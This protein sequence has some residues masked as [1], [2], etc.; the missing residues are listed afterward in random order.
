MNMSSLDT[1]FAGFVDNYLKLCELL[2]SFDLP[3]YTLFDEFK[4]M[5]EKSR[6]ILCVGTGR[7]GDVADILSKFLRNIGFHSYGPEELPYMFSKDDLVIAISGSGSTPYTLEIARFAKDIGIPIVGFTSNMDSPLARFLDLVFHIPG[8]PRRKPLRYEVVS[9]SGVYSTPLLMLGGTL[10]EL[11]SLLLI[12]SFI[13]YM[14]LGLDPYKIFAD[15]VSLCISFKPNSDQVKSLYTLIPKPRSISNPLSGK[16]VAVGEGLSG[17]VARFF[18]TR[19]RHCAH[20]DEERV[21]F[22]WRDRGSVAL[23]PGDLTLIVSGSGEGV[24]AIMARIAKMKES[25]VASITSYLDSELAKLSDVV[26]YVPGRIL[27]RIEG[28]RGSYLPT[29]PRYSIFELRTILLLETL[30]QSIARI[31]GLTEKDLW[32]HHPDFI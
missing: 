5:V 4:S 26:V 7:S 13:G 10:F 31:E 24:P 17:I 30:I 20:P 8:A 18:I 15:L 14:A 3:S 32:S 12:L 16:V 28:L 29:D 27:Q 25:R 22:Y 19:L 6:R 2:R 23:R 1:V 9:L 11:R 21:C